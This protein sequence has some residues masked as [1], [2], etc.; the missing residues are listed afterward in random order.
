M[1]ALRADRAPE[2]GGSAHRR[3]GRAAPSEGSAGAPRRRVTPAVRAEWTKLWSLPST[4]WLVAATAV[5]IAGVGAL[6]AATVDVEMCPTPTTCDEDTVKLALSGVWV[7]QVVAG[8]LGV[9]AATGE[10]GTRTIRTTLTADPLRLRVLAAKG[11]VVAVLVLCAGALGVAVALAI[12]RAVLAGN[13]FTAANG[14]AALTADGPTLRAAVGTVLYLGLVA[15]LA[16][17]IGT[18]VRD[19]ATGLVAVFALLFLP[20]LMVGLISDPVWVERLQKFAPSTAGLAVQATRHVDQLPIGPWA[21]VGVFAAYAGG[22]LVI[23]G[24]LLAAR[25]A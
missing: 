24:A 16:L 3:R 19:T 4:R 20:Q 13:G 22:A 5:L 18:A 21:G 15:L 1:R 12:G 7:G 11:V 10:Y 6:M 23:G 8:V 17:G 9:L 25:D 2:H 14:Y